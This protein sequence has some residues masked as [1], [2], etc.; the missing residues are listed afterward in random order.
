MYVCLFVGW[1][2]KDDALFMFFGVFVC[3]G[4]TNALSK[5]T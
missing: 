2:D 3:E 4:E 1:L 5:I